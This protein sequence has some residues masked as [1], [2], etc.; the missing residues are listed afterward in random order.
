VKVHQGTLSDVDRYIDSHRHI[1]L[2]DKQGDFDLIFGRMRQ[3]KDIGRGARLFEVGVGIGWFPVMCMQRGMECGGLEISPQLVDYANEFARANG[4]TPGIT[5]GNIE[6]Y[7]LDAD[8]YDA[9]VAT[10]TFE[11]VERWRDGIRKIFGALKPGGLFYFYSTNK[12]SFTSGEYN[13]PLYGWLPDAWR[14]RL[15]VARQGEEIM[16]LGID[17]NQFTHAGLRRVFTSVGFS[18][19]HDR[20]DIYLRYRASRERGLK[21]RMLGAVSGVRCLK[22]LALLFSSGTLFICIK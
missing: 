5:L 13:F 19:V 22:E 4:V 12:F 20:I 2:D 15:R 14:Y 11:H 21:Y 1:A 6:D 7:A 18:E 8:S 17:F 3:F 9:I 10:S 16:K